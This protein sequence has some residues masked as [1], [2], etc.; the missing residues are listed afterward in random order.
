LIIWKGDKLLLKMDQ[1]V[2]I[3]ALLAIMAGHCKCSRIYGSTVNSYSL[4]LQC[5]N[6]GQQMSV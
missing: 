3:T 6:E 4:S 1:V 5:K 2:C